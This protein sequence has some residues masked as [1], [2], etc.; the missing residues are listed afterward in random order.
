MTNESGFV[1]CVYMCVVAIHS[2]SP[3][4]PSKPCLQPAMYAWP[5]TLAAY[6]SETAL[7][8]LAAYMHSLQPRQLGNDSLL[9]MV[10]VAQAGTGRPAP[11]A[12]L[13]GPGQP[14]SA[15]ALHLRPALLLPLL[16]RAARPG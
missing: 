14:G 5:Q 1:V 8:P 7:W 3:Y 9:S 10:A 16:Q 11:A 2:Q 15:A 4:G 6:R 13:H 12:G